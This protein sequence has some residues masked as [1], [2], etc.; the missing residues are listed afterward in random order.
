M[1]LRRALAR[2]ASHPEEMCLLE[3]PKDFHYEKRWRQQTP[4]NCGGRD[5]GPSV[6]L[7][8]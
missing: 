4:Y 5:G 1:S 7:S 2:I 8:H 6:G 3:F